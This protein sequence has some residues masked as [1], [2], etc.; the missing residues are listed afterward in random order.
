MF[1]EPAAADI[2]KW[3]LVLEPSRRTQGL[4]RYG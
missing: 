4:M 2:E 1:P 3:N